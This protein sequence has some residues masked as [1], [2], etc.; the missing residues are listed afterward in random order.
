MPYTFEQAKRAFT[1]DRIR[2]LSLD[3]SGLRFLKLKSLSRTPLMQ[4]MADKLSLNIDGI[5]ARE[6]LQF[7]FESDVTDDQI[8]CQ[9]RDIYLTERLQRRNSE[10]SLISELYQVQ[11]FDWGGLHQNSLEKTI[12][13]N[14]VKKITSYNELCDTIDNKIYPSMKSYV[15]CSWYNH[16]TSIIIEDIFKDHENVLPAVGLIK[17]IDFFVNNIPFD[18]KVTYMPEGYIKNKRRSDGLRPELTLLK[19]F[20]RSNSI[21]FST[22]IPEARLLEDLWRKVKDH[23]SEE[24]RHLIIDLKSFRESLLQDSIIN[25]D[26]LII[27]LYENQG[28]RRFDSSNRLFLILV[29][30]ADFFASWQLKRAKPLLDQKIREKLSNQDPIGRNLT[31]KWE[32]ECFQAITDAIFVVR[33]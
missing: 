22:N 3:Q 27:W 17:K 10:Q 28:V 18:L 21:T 26:K 20:C 9:I 32:G 19:Q 25:P 2:E 29:D 12:V 4:R 8:N 6:L 5:P 30:K 16:W 1:S 33:E 15:L 24:A 7:L 11:T 23:P 14:Y 31:F 13:D